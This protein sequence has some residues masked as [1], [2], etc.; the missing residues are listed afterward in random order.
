MHIIRGQPEF[1]E[2]ISVRFVSFLPGNVQQKNAYITFFSLRTFFTVFLHRRD[3]E[4]INCHCTRA[5]DYVWEWNKTVGRLPRLSRT[6]TS[7]R[8]LR[9]AFLCRQRV[10]KLSI[11]GDGEKRERRGGGAGHSKQDYT[12]LIRISANFIE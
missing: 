1:Y 8:Y 7:R 5:T 12:S 2:S 10:N 11:E 4:T 3:V 9:C 6:T